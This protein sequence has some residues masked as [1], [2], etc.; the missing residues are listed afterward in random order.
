MMGKVKPEWVSLSLVLA[1]AGGI[2]LADVLSLALSLWISLFLLSLLG[3]FF[4]RSRS[5]IALVVCLVLAAL[6]LGAGRLQ[7]EAERCEALPH[8]A[9]GFTIFIIYLIAYYF[10]DRVC[11]ADTFPTTTFSIATSGYQQNT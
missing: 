5:R 2:T 3:L 10:I 4:F 7:L 8:Q 6:S 11:S 1:L 9:A